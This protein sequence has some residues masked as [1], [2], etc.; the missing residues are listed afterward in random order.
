MNPTLPTYTGAP[1]KK[2]ERVYKL[3]IFRKERGKGGVGMF[4]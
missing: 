1:D 4:L 2:G 3:P